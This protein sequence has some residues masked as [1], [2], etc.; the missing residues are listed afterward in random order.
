MKKIRLYTLVALL[1]MAGGVTMQA[2]EIIVTG[3][4][5]RVDAPYFEQN[6]CNDR[7]AM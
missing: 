2:Q 7:F 3:V 4:V 5:S 6:V 1:V